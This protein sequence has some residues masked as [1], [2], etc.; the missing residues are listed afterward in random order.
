MSFKDSENNPFVEIGLQALGSIIVPAAFWGAA[1]W[2][3]MDS[4]SK[5]YFN[6]QTEDLVSGLIVMGAFPG[7]PAG[8]VL[9]LA[10]AEIRGS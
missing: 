10:I 6:P 3:Y 7:I 9:G 8:V 5:G 2:L 1:Y 4:H